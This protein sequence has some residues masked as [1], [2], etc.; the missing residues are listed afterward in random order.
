MIIFKEHNYHAG[1]A[2]TSLI[3][4]WTPEVVQ[5]KIVLDEPAV[6]EML[7]EDPDSYQKRTSFTGR[8]D[9][10][11]FTEQHANVKVGVMGYPEKATAETGK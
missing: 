2:E 7:R 11:Q 9:E 4:Y 6:A 3:K 10:I 1:E 8:N 5:E